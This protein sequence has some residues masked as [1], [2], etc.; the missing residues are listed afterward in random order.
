VQLIATI[1][2]TSF[3]LPLIVN[4]E[5]TN[6]LLTFSVLLV[7]VTV[8]IYSLSLEMLQIKDDFVGYISDFWNW[9]DSLPPLIIIYITAKFY[10]G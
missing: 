7:M 10:T 9:I 6:S 2:F 1:Y 4:G 3:L 8:A 5:P